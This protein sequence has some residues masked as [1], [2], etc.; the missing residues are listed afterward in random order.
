M[1]LCYDAMLL[2]MAFNAALPRHAK[3]ERLKLMTVAC[4]RW[5]RTNPLSGT[6]GTFFCHH[7]ALQLKASLH[8]PCIAAFRKANC[9]GLAMHFAPAQNPRSNPV[10][11]RGYLLGGYGRS[12]SLC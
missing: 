9:H 1:T 11:T 10:L 12:V 4:V 5:F 6:D 3:D 2:N 8:V 7:L